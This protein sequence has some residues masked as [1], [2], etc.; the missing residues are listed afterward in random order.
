[1]NLH[2]RITSTK[3]K[4]AILAIGEL[5][6]M[7]SAA[8]AGVLI[9]P[10]SAS[11][12]MLGAS[13]DAVRD[14]SGLTPGYT[15]GVTELNAYLATNPYHIGETFS[16]TPP[17]GNINNCGISQ[18]GVITG[19]YDFEL[20]GSMALDALLFWNLG[21][22]LDDGANVKNFT[23][24]AA[25]NPSFANPTTIGSFTSNP[26]S[27]ITNAFVEIFPFSQ[28]FTASYVRLEITSN[29][30]DPLHTAFGELAFDGTP[31]PEP[32]SLGL[33]LISS[34]AILFRRKNR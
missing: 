19:N 24:L 16:G 17:V 3:A 8:H 15:S 28:T 1:M 32:A 21:L 33:L 23:L 30:G 13:A 20:G 29:Y 5:L 4:W 18:G 14:Q 6:L 7:V 11:T 27:P 12:N 22:G 9:D 10:V 2:Q 25:D 34:T 31:A 26:T